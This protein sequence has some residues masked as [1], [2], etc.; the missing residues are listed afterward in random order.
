MRERALPEMT[1]GQKQEF[2]LPGAPALRPGPN[3]GH[4]GRFVVDDQADGFG[5]FGFARRSPP[6]EKGTTLLIALPESIDPRA[7]KTE[8][9]ALFEIHFDDE[10]VGKDMANRD[11]IDFSAIRRRPLALQ[12]I[13]IVMKVPGDRQSHSTRPTLVAPPPRIGTR[14][15]GA[16]HPSSREQSPCQRRPSGTVRP[17]HAEKMS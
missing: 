3:A 17:P 16:R 15:P 9:K 1:Q 7:A 14:P 12:A 5:H 11:R 13:P 10:C 8:R 4:N 6:A 2:E